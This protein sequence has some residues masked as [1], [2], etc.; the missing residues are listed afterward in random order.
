MKYRVP[1]GITFSRCPYWLIKSCVRLLFAMPPLLEYAIG[2]VQRPKHWSLFPYELK[3]VQIQEPPGW[4][5]QC[6]FHVEIEFPACSLTCEYEGTLMED[7]M[8]YRYYGTCPYSDEWAYIYVRKVP[9][10]IILNCDFRVYEQKHFSVK[11]HTL[12]GRELKCIKGRIP[13]NGKVYMEQLK[14]MSEPA[15][16]DC[17]L[18]ISK[19]QRRQLVLLGSTEI[20][21]DR[22]IVFQ[23]EESKES[24]MHPIEKQLELLDELDLQPSQYMSIKKEILKDEHSRKRKREDQDEALKHWPVAWLNEYLWLQ[25]EPTFERWHLF[26]IICILWSLATCWEILVSDFSC[27]NV[28]RI[29]DPQIEL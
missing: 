4:K 29:N 22:D 25:G 12:S 23:T 9:P 11:F 6:T 19:N 16:E 13:D 26:L 15:I 8:T 17:Q 2:K 1:L 27:A 10:P 20:L 14:H 21:R 28:V 24:L 18:R 3:S 5:L 7:G